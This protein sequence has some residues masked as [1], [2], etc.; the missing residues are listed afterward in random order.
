MIADTPLRWA[1]TAL[2]VFAAGYCLYRIT[3]AARWT[4]RIDHGFH[5]VMCVAMIAMAWPWGLGVPPIPQGVLFTAAAVW[6]AIS[7]A[8]TVPSSVGVDEHP[9]GPLMGSYHAFMM[10]AMVWMVAVMAGW[11]PGTAAHDHTADASPDDMAGMGTHTH[12]PD[13]DM[14]THSHTAAMSGPEWISTISLTL[15]AAFAVAAI[16]WLYCLVAAE[17][18]AALALTYSS[19]SGSSPSHSGTPDLGNA[20]VAVLPA[21]RRQSVAAACE[22][23]MAAG[24]AIMMG[25]M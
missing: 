6:F 10:A 8:R 9:H 3:C 5:L 7:A 19:R 12:T 15:T 25:V 2:F 24:M 4:V 16:L 21:L 13:M 14:S 17:Q 18:T 23:A 20:A 1:T 22:V 11:L